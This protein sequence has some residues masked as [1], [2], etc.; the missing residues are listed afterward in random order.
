MC[1]ASVSRVACFWAAQYARKERE[2]VRLRSVCLTT[3]LAFPKNADTG[4]AGAQRRLE[5]R[6]LSCTLETKA[7]EGNPA[8]SRRRLRSKSHREAPLGR[9]VDVLK[10][11]IFCLKGMLCVLKVKEWRESCCG[12]TLKSANQRN[13]Q[14]HHKKASCSKLYS[15]IYSSLNLHSS[16][17]ASTFS[18]VFEFF[19]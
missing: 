11:S 17:N 7:T 12:S 18:H 3:T 10:S 1:C 2:K 19:F 6:N 9:R 14:S 13:I 4:W 5:T 8:D 16:K 15:R